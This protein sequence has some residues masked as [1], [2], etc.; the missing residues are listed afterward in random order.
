MRKISEKEIITEIGSQFSLNA[1]QWIAFWIIADY[2]IARY[3]DK[4]QEK[5]SDDQLIM[6]VTGPGGS[7]A[8]LIDG[9]TMCKGLG[10]K[11][12]SNNKDHAL[13]YAKEKPDLWFRGIAIIFAGD[14]YQF[15]PV[16]G[17]PLYMPISLYAGQND[18][19]IWGILK[20][21]MWQ[22]LLEQMNYT[23]DKI[24]SHE[25]SHAE[26]EILLQ[27]NIVTLKAAH[28]PPG[29]V[30]LFEGMPV[31]LKVHLSHIP[32]GYFPILPSM[33]TFTTS[34]DCAEGKQEKIHVTHYQVPIQP[35]FAVTGHSA[36]GK[37]LPQVLV[38]LHEGSFAAYV[39]ASCA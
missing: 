5:D 35:A 2:F 8:A 10:I 12:K 34:I 36:Q 28:G 33:W 31:I 27:L 3:V 6:L 26:H 37:T 16:G 7:T 13:R 32:K 39:S 1:K 25:L 19:E 4:T 20:I 22:P 14:F 24:S 29:Y 9:M 30:M 15:P 18:S 11:I 21:L 38:N 17:S 23:L